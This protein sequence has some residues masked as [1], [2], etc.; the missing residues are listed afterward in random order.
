MGLQ[1]HQVF[2]VS[3]GDTN[4]G[5]HAHAASSLLTQSS[6]YL[7]NENI[8]GF[9]F[10]SRCKAI[11]PRSILI[12]LILTILF[13]DHYLGV[14]LFEVTHCLF[15]HFLCLYL[16]FPLTDEPSD[17]PSLVKVLRQHPR[18]LQPSTKSI[19][20]VLKQYDLI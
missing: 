14:K 13:A 3:P 15:S 12:M 6:P 5:P 20:H 2:S 7:S 16:L 9:F 18:P 17:L 8:I 4:S 11:S 1:A 19:R 10:L